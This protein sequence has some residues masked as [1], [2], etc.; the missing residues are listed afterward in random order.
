MEY[1]LNLEVLS[2]KFD[3]YSDYSLNNIQ[4]EHLK[5]ASLESA[6]LL[7]KDS[8]LFED[9]DDFLTKFND[10]FGETDIVRMATTKL[11]S[12]HQ[13]SHLASVYAADFSQLACDDWDDNT[14]INAF[15]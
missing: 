8:L 11:R 7:K 2:N 3:L 6:P 9:L 10:T 15:W 12:L 4:R 1:D 14:L 5:L 13:G